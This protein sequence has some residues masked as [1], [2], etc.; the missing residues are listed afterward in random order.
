M[1]KK[2]NKNMNMLHA[3]TFASWQASG[4]AAPVD[5]PDSWAQSLGPYM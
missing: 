2:E 4:T 5:S 1:K 3:E